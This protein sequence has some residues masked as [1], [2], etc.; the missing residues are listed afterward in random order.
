MDSFKDMFKSARPQKL[1]TVFRNNNSSLL[2]KYKKY[3][4]IIGV[5]V[6]IL[7]ATSI[8]VV[9]MLIRWLWNVTVDTASTNPTVSSVVQNTKTRVS[10][11]VPTVPSTAQDFI[12]NGAIDTTKLQQ[13]YNDLPTQ[14]QG[15]WKAAVESSINQQI[16]AA[17]GAS[18]QQLQDMLN[19]VRQL[20]Q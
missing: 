2:K 5:F 15:I 4:I 14:T 16:Q 9:I 7:I 20:G 12:T 19:A 10:D 1:K 8:I 17:T 6:T 3:F 18:L 13:V 11:L